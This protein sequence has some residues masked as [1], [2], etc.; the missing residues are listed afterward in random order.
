MGSPGLRVERLQM[1]PNNWDERAGTLEFSFK[2]DRFATID[3]REPQNV[4]CALRTKR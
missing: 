2:M 4:G 1:I 3:P